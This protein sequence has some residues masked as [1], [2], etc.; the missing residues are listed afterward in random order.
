[1]SRPLCLPTNN[2]FFVLFKGVTRKFGKL[3]SIRDSVLTLEININRIVLLL[4]PKN[5]LSVL[6]SSRFLVFN[7]VRY[8]K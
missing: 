1:M 5:V 2:I 3:K 6:F 4:N 8:V 7:R